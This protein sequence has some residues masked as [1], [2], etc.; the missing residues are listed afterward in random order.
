MP[1][2][3]PK[4][5]D[6]YCNTDNFSQPNTILS[7]G[8]ATIRDKNKNLMI[9][10]EGIACSFCC[11]TTYIRKQSGDYS[12]RQNME[13]ILNYVFKLIKK[14][15]VLHIPTGPTKIQ[16]LE[17]GGEDTEEELRKK[18]ENIEVNMLAADS[19]NSMLKT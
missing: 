12:D 17:Y 1:W 5:I 11:A 18:I 8:K 7:A 13:K 3:I 15:I 6:T 4:S 19:P 2:P 14:K 16:L 9:S 10:I